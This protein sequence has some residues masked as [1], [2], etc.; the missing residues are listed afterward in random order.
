M[1]QKTIWDRNNSNLLSLMALVISGVNFQTPHKLKIP[2]AC[3]LKYT[4]IMFRLLIMPKIAK[5][6]KK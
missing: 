5:I 6:I 4:F 3:T 2:K 1:T